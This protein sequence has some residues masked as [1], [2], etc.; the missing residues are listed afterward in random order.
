MKTKLLFCAALVIGLITELKAQDTYFTEDFGTSDVSSSTY[1]SATPVNITS[2]GTW[3]VYQLSRQG[4]TCPDAATNPKALKMLQG[5]G[6]YVILPYFSNGVASV[7]FTEG[8]GQTRKFTV[9]YSTSDVTDASDASWVATPQVSTGA[10]GTSGN[11]V[12]VAINNASVK[13]I[14][15]TM[16][17][18]S[19]GYLDNV[20]VTSMTPLP[21]DFLSFNAAL[22][23]G[24]AKQVKLSWSTTNEVNTKDFT[25]E[26]SLDGKSFAA[27]GS[28]PAQNTS[29]IHT[30]S[31]TDNNPAAGVNYYRLKQTDK[32]GAYIYY[33]EIRSVNNVADASLAVYP[34]PAGE[35]ITVNYP[36]ANAGA[37]LKVLTL[38]G[39]TV[40]TLNV[41]QGSAQAT[42]ST[43]G[44]TPGYYLLVFDN[45][46]GKSSVKFLKQ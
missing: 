2:S 37:E 23:A 24:F 43:A 21:L 10:C 17:H 35:N 34:N 40:S 27:T 8:K 31:Y 16:D 25:I 14:K 7:T 18:T 15:I 33:K 32:D 38:N 13:R 44:L 36:T 11:T 5:V 6:S 46:N 19:D 41:A 28:V 3:I 22:T 45:G 30:Y 4:A 26:R 29:G 42:T 9:Y 1:T 20:S 12:T 39:K